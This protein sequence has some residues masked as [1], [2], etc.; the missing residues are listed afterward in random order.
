ML[1]C[2]IGSLILVAIC[3]HIPFLR[4]VMNRRREQA[5]REQEQAAAWRLY[6]PSVEEPSPQR[7]AA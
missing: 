5:M 1:C 4:G 3:S 6:E 7:L 2:V